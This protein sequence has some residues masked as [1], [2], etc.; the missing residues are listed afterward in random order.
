MGLAQTRG[1]RLIVPGQLGEHILWLDVV[2]VVVQHALQPTY[3]A[4]GSQRGSAYLTDAF[5][6]GICHRKQLVALLVEQ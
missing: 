1:E 4:D 5:S 2:R 6:D 3:M